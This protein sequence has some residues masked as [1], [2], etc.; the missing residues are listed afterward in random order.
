MREQKLHL[1][2]EEKLGEVLT[3]DHLER[4]K[5]FKSFSGSIAQCLDL[6]WNRRPKADER[7]REVSGGLPRLLYEL[8]DENGTISSG[9]WRQ[10]F[11]KFFLTQFEPLGEV[12]V[13]AWDTSFSKNTWNRRFSTSVSHLVFIVLCASTYHILQIQPNQARES[14][15]RVCRRGLWSLVVMQGGEGVRQMNTAETMEK[16]KIVQD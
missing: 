1:G 10:T 4:T 11:V 5:T 6:T 8:N 13:H 12:F 16:S 9:Q 3:I 7:L 14:W 2:G 15:Q